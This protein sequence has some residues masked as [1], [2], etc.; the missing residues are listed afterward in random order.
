MGADNRGPTAREQLKQAARRLIGQPGARLGIARPRPTPAQTPRIALPRQ[1]L[2]RVNPGVNLGAQARAVPGPAGA[3]RPP[4]RIAA[5]ISPQR[6]AVPDPPVL[7]KR[8]RLPLVPAHPAARTAVAMLPPRAVPVRAEHPAAVPVA[9]VADAVA[10]AGA[11]EEGAVEKL[12]RVQL[13]GG[14]EK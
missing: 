5:V 1:M 6:G 9:V 12:P 4:L 14:Y 13:P 3:P 11:V 8:D 10:V 7:P 2:A